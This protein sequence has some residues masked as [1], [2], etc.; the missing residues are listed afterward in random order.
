MVN[1]L[2]K[3]I[4]RK[5]KIFSAAYKRRG[6]RFIMEIERKWMVSGWPDQ[7]PL[8]FTEYQEQGYVH[9]QAPV[10]RIRMEAR[11][12]PGNLPAAG[13]SGLHADAV[14]DCATEDDTK[15]V[16]CFKSRGLLSRKEIEIDLA[17]ED[18]LKLKDLIGKPL[19]RK[20]RNVYRLPD[21]LHLEVNLVDED[22]ETEFMYAEVEYASEEQANAWDPG[23]FALASYLDD[24]VT[25]KPGQ[26]M[27]AYWL[28]TR[29]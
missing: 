6:R 29:K 20:V 16:L 28:Q 15:Y 17:K 8:L 9:A 26:S 4:F 23:A 18:Y 13:E 19:I 5:A 14:A 22:L 7:L 12:A 25:L 10:V 2:Q 27:S 21:G 24:D 3:R 1:C 11:I